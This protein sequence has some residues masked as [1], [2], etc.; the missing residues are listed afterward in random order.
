MKQIDGAANIQAL[1][2]LSSLF[3]TTSMEIDE[4]LRT[5]IESAQEVVGAKNAS[6]LMVEDEETK[7]LKFYQ[8]SGKN[9]GKLKDIDI[10]SGVGIAG[11]VLKTGQ[12]IISNDVQNDPR[13]YRK[14]SEKV[15]ISVQSIA[16]FPLLNGDKVIG[17]LQFLDKRDGSEFGSQDIDILARF[18]GIMAKFFNVSNNKKV[19]GQEFDRLRENYLQRYLIVGESEP[20]QNCIHLAERVADSKA[21]VLITGESGTGKELFA[22]LIHNSSPRQNKPFVSVSCG[23]LPASIL[24]RELFGHEKGAF[25]GADS[26]KIGLFE[27]ADTGTL[28][29]DE[30]GE[31]P[32][33]MQVK[34]LRVLQE[35]SFMRLG[36]TKT[37]K[38]DV[39]I[40]TATNRDLDQEV[41]D[42]SF[43]KDLFYRINVINIKLPSLR[44]RKEDIPDLVTY[45]LRKHNPQNQ[46]L[47]KPQKDLMPHLMGYSWPGNIRELE[48]SIERALVLTEG[49]ELGPDIFPLESTQK[50]IEINVGSTLK[51]G[52]DSFRRAFIM[53]TLKSTAGN[54]TK[55][56]KILDVQRSYLSRLI[57]ELGID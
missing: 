55:A 50:P 19:L 5:V 3:D 42:G 56:A 46:P 20:I 13:W 53:N 57:K 36:G 1:R 51:E 48:N 12:A 40:I 26:M 25:T 7:N 22:Q 11:L 52:S 28:F 23:A 10:P 39:R 47:K 49:E 6:L 8:A 24:E 18:S 9:M 16:C 54:R 43:R 4:L 38:V 44:E 35:E 41:Q 33:D 14:V 32:M 34:L 37:L 21:P 30:I 15:K 45:F 27:A 31:M 29:L 2:K 17:V